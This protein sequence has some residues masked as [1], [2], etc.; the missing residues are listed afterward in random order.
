[1]YSQ[2]KQSFGDLLRKVCTGILYSCTQPFVD[3]GPISRKRV[4][5]HVSF[6][7]HNMKHCEAN[8]EEDSGVATLASGHGMSW[9]KRRARLKRIRR[10]RSH[11]VIQNTGK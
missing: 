7:S 8:P 3:G 9:E 2:N 1:M 11:D 4:E 6:F 10:N 5:C